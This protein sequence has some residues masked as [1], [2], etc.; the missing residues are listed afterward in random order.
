[1]NLEVRI[2]TITLAVNEKVKL[3]STQ[4]KIEFQIPILTYPRSNWLSQNA[5]SFQSSIVIFP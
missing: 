5:R 3:R 4:K 1:M 2:I